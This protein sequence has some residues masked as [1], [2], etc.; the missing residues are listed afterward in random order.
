ERIQ[1]DDIQQLINR[2]EVS[3]DDAFTARFPKEM[4]SA[5]EVQ[6]RS[7]DVLHARA[8]SYQGFTNQPLDRDGA[9]AKFHRLASPFTGYD[10]ARQIADVVFTLEQRPLDELTG[11]LAKVPLTRGKTQE[12]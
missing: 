7:G 9:F 10:L 3:P 4:P 8:D 2:I 1:A 6:L 5:V 12:A 11:L